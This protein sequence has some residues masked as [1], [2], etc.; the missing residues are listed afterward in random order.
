[1]ELTLLPPAVNEA[2]PAVVAILE[3]LLTQARLGEVNGVA[4]VMAYPQGGEA[5][6][7]TVYALNPGQDFVGFLG[8]LEVLKARILK[9]VSN[10]S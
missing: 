4:I 1:M 10:A 3:R 6:F 7:G 5:T 8:M 2:A 9:D